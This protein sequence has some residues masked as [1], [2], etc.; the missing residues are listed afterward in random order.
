[1]AVRQL[2][3]QEPVLLREV[4]GVI[5]DGRAVR[6]RAVTGHHAP[7]QERVIARVDRVLEVA[8]DAAF[9]HPA[10]DGIRR[11]VDVDD[12]DQALQLPPRAEPQSHAHD[13]AE[14]P[15]SADDQAEQL[16]VPVARALDDLAVRVDQGKALDILADWPHHQAAPVGVAGHG[17]AEREGIG[18]GLLLPDR[19]LLLAAR[20]LPRGPD[21]IRPH[22]SRLHGEQAAL[23]VERDRPVHPGH[24]QEQAVR[25]ELLTAHR[26]TSTADRQTPAPVV[27]LLRAQDLLPYIVDSGGPDDLE[28]A[29]RVQPRMHVVDDLLH[30]RAP[31]AVPHLPTRTARTE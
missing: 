30:A 9:R 6:R 13:H 24:V 22:R 12:V 31:P 18:T 3:K 10:V 29:G 21:H 14:E 25:A 8:V 28:Y 16:R 19:V 7:A 23:L 27:R 20:E 1:M 17:A 4:L 15:I 5:V 26:M 2:Q 11:V